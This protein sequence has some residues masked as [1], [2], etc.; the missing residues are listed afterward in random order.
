MEGGIAAHRTSVSYC[1]PA[2]GDDTIKA[3]GHERA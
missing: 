3:R 2:T 1:L